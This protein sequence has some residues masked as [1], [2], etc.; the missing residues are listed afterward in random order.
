MGRL[1]LIPP[2]DFLARE[3]AYGIQTF[4]TVLGKNN[5]LDYE[6]WLAGRLAYLGRNIPP[7]LPRGLIHGDVFYDNVLIEG[8]QLKAIIDFEN[9]CWYHIIFELGMGIV[10]LCSPGTKVVLDKARALVSGYQRVRKLDDLEKESLQLFVEYAAIATSYWRFWK[11]HMDIPK[12]ETEGTH[13]QMVQIA[14]DARSIPRERFLEAIFRD[15][16]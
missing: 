3:H 10:G 13:W 7:G 12:T 9:V 6:T 4:H 11:F 15:G 16:I 14:E 2:P 8:K 5:G 1:N